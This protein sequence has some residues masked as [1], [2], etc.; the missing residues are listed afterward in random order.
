MNRIKAFIITALLLPVAMG[1]HRVAEPQPRPTAAAG[2]VAVDGNHFVLADSVWFPLMINYC[3]QLDTDG[4]DTTLVAAPYYTPGTMADH[5]AAIAAWGF[6]S[7]RL[8][9]DRMADADVGPA[10]G[11]A[12]RCVADLAEDNGLRLMVLLRTPWNR[13][14]EQRIATV[15]DSLADCTAVW[16]YD[17]MNEPLYFD[18]EPDR[19]KNNA[20]K[21]A[22]RWRGLVQQHAPHQLF[23]IGQAEPI[24]VFEW[25]PA[26]LPVD[27]VQVHTYHPLRVASEMWWYGRYVGR[28][29]MVG[30]TSLPA[31]GDSVPTEWQA[32]FMRESFACAV[33]NGAAGY[34]WWEFQDFADG[35]N[36]EAQYS[37]L[38]F[39]DGTVKPAA[40]AVADL[41]NA[42][43]ANAAEHPANYYNMLAYSNMA[44]C[45]RVVDSRGNPIE[46][47]VVRGW[48]D[49]WSVGM[50]TYTRADGSFALCCNDICVHFEVSAP[51]YS[52][53]KFNAHPMF[54][55]A[56]PDPGSLPQRGREYQS[57]DYKPYLLR[58]ESMLAF[59][60]A[61]FAIPELRATIPTVR[62]KRLVASR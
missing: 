4:S 5:F 20:V 56:E 55:G 9:A 61:L 35:V 23:T 45:G 11:H 43:A 34:G 21:L 17:F 49:D 46:G 18:P 53:A 29:W 22:S 15:L 8:C 33:A 27:F 14:Q 25:D 13:Q 51:C 36:F 16:A 10:L 26:L 58:E 24:E 6:N 28:P 31:D 39:A 3:V 62:L 32:T 40:A 60:T 57:I 19:T 38:R 48:N 2:Y 42:K 1:C 59:D 7:V 50:N 37:G 12:L 52:R 47:A 54:E 41:K 30:E 44:I